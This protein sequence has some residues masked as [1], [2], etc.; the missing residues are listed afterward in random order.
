MLR[1][2]FE[3][4]SPIVIL[5]KTRITTT[6]I[7]V[8]EHLS[9]ERISNVHDVVHCGTRFKRSREPRAILSHNGFLI[10]FGARMCS[11]PAVRTICGASTNLMAW[12]SVLPGVQV[13]PIRGRR[14]TTDGMEILSSC[15]KREVCSRDYYV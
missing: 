13:V 15:C 1:K 11:S 2:S 7:G 3:P 12:G 8:Y 9:G 4:C 10:S 14:N 5:P 6:Y